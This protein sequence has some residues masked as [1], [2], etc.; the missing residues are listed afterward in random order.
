MLQINSFIGGYDNNFTYLIWCTETQSGALVDA[1][2][3]V[4]P[5]QQIVIESNLNLG[6]I[7]LT[8]THGDHLTYLE[9]WLALYP[10]LEVLGHQKPEWGNLPNYRGLTDGTTFN[11]GRCQLKVI[12]TPGHYPDCVCWYEKRGGSLFTGDTVFVGRTG[13]TLSPRSSLQQLYY[14]VYERILNLPAATVVYPGHDYGSAPTTSLGELM[15]SS[16]FFR[17]SSETEFAEVMT[18]FERSRGRKI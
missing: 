6:H 2:T 11:L 12:E 5:I 16:D 1:A 9:E 18:R 8:H 3:P 13:R 10:G 4:R 15:M 14:S 17:C 7:L